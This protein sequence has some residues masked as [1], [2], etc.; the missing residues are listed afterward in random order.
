VARLAPLAQESLRDRVLSAVRNAVVRGEFRPGEKVSEA[1]LAEQLGVSRTPV[2]EALRVLEY[3]GLVVTRPKAGTYIAAPDASVLRNGLIV[4]AT[5]EQLALREVMLRGGDE[6]W[7]ALCDQLDELLQRMDA[8]VR[9]DDDIGGTEADICWHERLV[10]AAGN[11]SLTR[12]WHTV[13]SP[14]LVWAAEI[15][16]YPL[17]RAAWVDVVEQHQRLLAIFRRADVE[18]SAHA[19]EE[20]IIGKLDAASMPPSEDGASSTGSRAAKE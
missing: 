7:H 4:R 5:L 8:A 3:Q 15:E 13:G 11:A 16:Q 12:A 10:T 18:E 20:H 17:E 1:E 2:R 6:G 9:G 14:T 19:I